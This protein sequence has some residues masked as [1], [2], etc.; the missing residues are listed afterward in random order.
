MQ[1]FYDTTDLILSTYV[2]Q[3]K[4]EAQESNNKTN[5]LIKIWK[6]DKIKF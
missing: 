4:A 5:L 1:P 3:C 6:S 2:N